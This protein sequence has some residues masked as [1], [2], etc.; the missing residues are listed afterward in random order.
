MAYICNKP[1]DSCKT[2]NHFRWD[3]DYQGYA[4]W[5]EVDGKEDRSSQIIEDLKWF[6]FQDGTL[7]VIKNEFDF[8]NPTKFVSWTG[9]GRSFII[10]DGDN[11]YRIAISKE[12]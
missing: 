10:T 6:L 12:V 7:D 1:K 4:C 2:C 3:E 5:A 11:E 8:E 9:D